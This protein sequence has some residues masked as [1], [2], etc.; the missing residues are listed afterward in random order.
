[1]GISWYFVGTAGRWRERTNNLRDICYGFYKLYIFAARWQAS[2][3]AVA[4]RR[5][6]RMRYDVAFIN[7]SNT[8]QLYKKIIYRTIFLKSVI[9]GSQTNFDA[10]KTRHKTTERFLHQMS[11]NT[12]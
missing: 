7:Y 12:K 2:E 8:I 1:M 3:A 11:P 6:G 5:R 9:A 4:T 10:V